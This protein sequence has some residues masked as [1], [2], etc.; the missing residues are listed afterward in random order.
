MCCYICKTTNQK[1]P[2][3]FKRYFFKSPLFMKNFNIKRVSSITLSVLVLS[4]FSCSTDEESLEILDNNSLESTS[5]SLLSSK[6]SSP[7]DYAGQ[8]GQHFQ[9]LQSVGV[10]SSYY[11]SGTSTKTVKGDDLEGYYDNNIF[12]LS[13]NNRMVLESHSTNKKRTELKETNSNA[14]GTFHT[15]YY[16]AYVDNIPADGVTIAQIHNR[17]G[18]EKPLLRVEIGD[19]KKIHIIEALTIKKAD[20]DSKYYDKRVSSFTYKENERIIVRLRLLSNGKVNVYVKYGTQTMARTFTPESQWRD[21]KVAKG[22][23]FKA[24]VYNDSGDGRTE[25]LIA[26]TRFNVY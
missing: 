21:S 4:L 24:G 22:Y 19:D 11:D 16:V 7:Y 13:T 17:E 25:P 10:E 15:M 18:A 6:N 8:S 9:G 1:M 23:Y 3:E 20:S 2:Y 5:S 26:F 12:W 14:L